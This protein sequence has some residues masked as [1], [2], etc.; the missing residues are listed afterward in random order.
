MIS[1]PV[2]FLGHIHAPPP[3]LSSRHL[4]V[5][6]EGP[7]TISA[8]AAAWAC[9]SGLPN[10]VVLVVSAYRRRAVADTGWQLEGMAPG[11]LRERRTKRS[12]RYLRKQSSWSGPAWTKSP[13]P[14]P[15]KL[16]R[17]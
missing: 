16:I 5:E 7:G 12:C 13:V 17:V 8:K 2:H 11:D 15:V 4:E 9:Q 1:A 14:K 10:S 3:A 6:V